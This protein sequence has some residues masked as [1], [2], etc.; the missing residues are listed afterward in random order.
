M[1]K[2]RRSAHLIYDG[3]MLRLDTS[4]T[5][6][7]SVVVSNHITATGGLEERISSNRSEN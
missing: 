2:A 5:E 4:I 1:K 3:S 7:Y 6:D